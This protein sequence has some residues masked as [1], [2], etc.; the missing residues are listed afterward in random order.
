MAMVNMYVRSE[1]QRDLRETISVSIK[2]EKSLK[3][4]ESSDLQKGF[5]P[6]KRPY[7]C[8]GIVQNNYQKTQNQARTDNFRFSCRFQTV[9]LIT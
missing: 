3:S 2:R 1:M 8:S 4:H 5:S 9:S 7:R 6:Q